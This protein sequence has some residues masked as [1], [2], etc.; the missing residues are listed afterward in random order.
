MWPKHAI[1]R[2]SVPHCI[3]LKGM[4][5]KDHRGNTVDR[6]E[7]DIGPPAGW[8]D[9]RRHVE[10]RIPKTQEIEVSDDEWATYFG[11]GNGTN[12]NTT[13]GEPGKGEPEKGA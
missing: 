11:N 10:R 13:A 2:G 9:R 3:E 8:R 12:G 1:I 6:R 5:K 4:E 7:E